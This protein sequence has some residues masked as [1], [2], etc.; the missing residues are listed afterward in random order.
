MEGS[1]SS[2]SQIVAQVGLTVEAPSEE[3]THR[4]KLAVTLMNL[5]VLT[6]A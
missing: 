3:G 2:I 5:P 6:L 1:G 4:T